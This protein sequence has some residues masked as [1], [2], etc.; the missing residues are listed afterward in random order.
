ME[1]T[2]N[3]KAW[4]ASGMTMIAVLL[5]FFGVGD[6]PMPDTIRSALMDLIMVGASGV[7]SY[8]MTW[9]VANKKVS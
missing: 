9:L 6:M 2:A 4:M 8:F 5:S 7:V 1:K 3:T